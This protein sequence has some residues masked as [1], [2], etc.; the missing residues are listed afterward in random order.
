MRPGMEAINLL[1]NLY[2]TGV[3]QL[4][5]NGRQKYNVYIKGGR[6]DRR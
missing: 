1:E 6:G 2:Y 3:T 5:E 4:E